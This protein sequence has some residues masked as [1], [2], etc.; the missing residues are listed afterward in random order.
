MPYISTNTCINPPLHGHTDALM[1]SW[2][3]R[4]CF[5]VRHN[6][7]AEGAHILHWGCV[8][9]FIIDDVDGD[10]PEEDTED[11][12]GRSESPASGDPSGVPQ[13]QDEA[14]RVEQIKARLSPKHFVHDHVMKNTNFGGTVMAERLAR[15][16][17]TKANRAQYPAGSPDFRKWESCRLM[18][19]PGPRGVVVRLLAPQQGEPGSIPGGA[20]PGFSHVGIVPDD[21]AGRR[22]FSGI[23]SFPRPCIPALL[24]THLA[25]SSPPPKTSMFR[26]AQLLTHS[27]VALNMLV[28]E[29]FKWKVHS[30][31]AVSTLASHQGESG[32]IPGQVTGFS[33]VG[34]VLDDAVWLAGFLG[35]LQIPPPPHSGAAPYSFQS[36]SSALKTSLLRAAQ[37]SSLTLRVEAESRKNEFAKL[38]EEH[39]QVVKELKKME[40]EPLQSRG[41]GQ[42]VTWWCY[43][44]RGETTLVYLELFPAFE[45]ERRGTVKGDTATRIRSTI[46]AKRRALNWRAVFSSCCVYPWDFQ[47]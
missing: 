24:H 7:V 39:A 47:R 6:T 46:A 21:V 20:A 17:P 25:S 11:Q 22:V 44:C 13:Q 37:I 32:S 19:L 34:I 14:A 15:W 8:H 4:D 33:Q 10:I 26:A 9:N 43:V 16:P 42:H 2:K 27:N 45:A 18:P 12:R 36:P 41:K 23:S 29:L 5:A 3:F 35:V 1:N 31:S 40:D 38:L 28:L 30:G